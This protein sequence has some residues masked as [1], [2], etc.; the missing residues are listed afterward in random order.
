VTGS[1]TLLETG[2]TKIIVDCGLHQ[3]SRDAEETNWE[4]PSYEPKE[5]QFVIITHSH[6][7]H[8]G[9][10][11]YL[12]RLGFRGK[13]ISTRP[14][15]EFARIFLE[16]TCRLMTEE[17]KDHRQEP[18]FDENDI[19]G[20]LTLFETTD[21]YQAK[22]LTENIQVKLYDAGHILG[23]AIVEIK[24]EGKTLIFSGD[25][26]NPPVPILRDTDFIEKADYVVME[27]TYG[28]RN[29]D[30]Y[31]ER[32]IKLERAIEK[33]IANSGVLLLPAFAMERTQEILFEIN[34]LIEKSAIPK[35][36][37][38]IDSPLAIKA[39]EIYKKFPD[40]Y[41]DESRKL[42]E[43]GDDIFKFPGAVFT[44]SSEESK[45]IDLSANPKIII[46]GSGMSTGGRILFHERKYLPDPNSTLLIIGFQVERSLGRRI[47]DGE[48]DIKIQG[49]NVHVQASVD[50]IEAYSAHAD[51]QRLK[52]W[53]SKIA[54]PIYPV[55][56]NGD[57]NIG[58][59]ATTFS[60][61]VKK[62]F[63]IH[64]EDEP[65]NV[66]MHQIKDEL[67]LEVAIP[68]KNESF[69]I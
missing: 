22:D 35:I 56:D 60:N 47:K 41:D 45:K 24:A 1:N 65:K 32:K 57:A 4:K 31:Q 37:V 36:P 28:D 43:G 68:K 64:G 49:Q 2:G 14:V 19:N 21:Y 11:P 18:L 48:K 66:L 59:S 38:Y 3:G 44:K 67:G 26:G 30:P 23:S 6:I 51:Q 62:V 33:V 42:V 50:A 5:I 29:H 27:S 16:D 58:G 39:T 12:Y 54:R 34:D 69:E 55:R 20:V 13:V 7:D 63:L 9:R 25:L 15:V 17:A 40:Y 10:L 52:F 8:I 53:L 46:A 61:G